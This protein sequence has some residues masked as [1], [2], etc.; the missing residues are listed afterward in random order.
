MCYNVCHLRNSR[1]PIRE[2]ARVKHH[3]R[4]APGSPSPLGATVYPEGVHFAL[5]SKNATAVELLLFDHYD[6]PQP[7]HVIALDPAVNRTFYY[8]HVLVFGLKPGQ[9]YAYRVDGPCAPEQGHRFNA[10]KVLLDPYAREIIYGDNWSRKEAMG[11]APNCASAMKNVVVDAGDYDWGGDRPLH[12]AFNDTV[13]YEMHVS[14]LTKHPSSGVEH[15]GTY[16]GVIEK[17]PYLKSMGITAVELLPVQQFDEQDV[18]DHRPTDGSAGVTCGA[19]YWGYN[20]IGFFAPHRGYCTSLEHSKPVGEF[21]DMVKALHKAGIEVILDVVFNHTAEGDHRGPTMSFRGLENRAYYLLEPDH[22]LYSDYA[23]TGNTLNGNHSIVRRLILD[24]LH[25]WVDEMHVDGFRFD[26]A[27]VLSRDEWGQPMRS[28]PILWD[29]ES[30][31]RLVG[32]KMIAEAWDA[33]GLYQ[34]G[35]FV[36]HRWAEWNGRYRDDVRRFLRADDGTVTHFL[37]RVTGSTDIYTAPDHA[38]HR[39]INFVTCH[40]GFTLNDLVSYNRKHNE[41]NGEDNRDGTDQNYSHNYGHEG[42]TDDPAIEAVRLRQIKNA[43]A[44][45]MVSQGTPMLLYGD[46]VRRTQRGN[47]NAYCQD[48]ELSWFNWEDVEKHGDLLR[49]VRRMVQFNREHPVLNLEVYPSD[50]SPAQ[51]S[52]EGTACL[53]D[54]VVERHIACHGVKLNQPDLGYFSHSIVLQLRGQSVGDDDLHIAFNAYWEDLEFELPA[55]PRNSPWLRAVDTSLPTPDDI[56]DPGQERPVEEATYV[57]GA[58]SV[59]ILIAHNKP[60]DA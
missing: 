9:I 11:P 3:F 27:S 30:D 34:V 7:A 51:E 42:P 8:W 47:N 48:S 54:E 59:V 49:F 19:N 36:G 1:Y 22:R 39:S 31:P 53:R 32:T 38:L 2:G 21:R 28:P 10:N 25:Y 41:D 26:L 16:G 56:V 15:P 50:S 52:L 35:T 57:A 23:G 58:R 33:A 60:A 17:V 37:S 43:V 46:E 55:R 20:P 44:I 45:L 14:G 24:A 4:T 13:I 12:C 29:I 5:F 40:D 18:L 6:T